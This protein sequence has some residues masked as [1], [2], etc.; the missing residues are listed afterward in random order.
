MIDPQ[1]EWVDEHTEQKIIN[2]EYKIWKKNSPFLYDVLY[3]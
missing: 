2:E 3:R 1:Q